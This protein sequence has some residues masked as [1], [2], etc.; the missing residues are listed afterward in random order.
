M[1][2]E[3]RRLLRPDGVLVIS[4]PERKEYSEL[5]DFK[6]EYH[7]HEFYQDEFRTFLED[8]FPCVEIFGQR[9]ISASATWP[10][11]GATP[12]SSLQTDPVP[13]WHSNREVGTGL[14]PPQYCI[15]VCGGPEAFVQ[16]RLS[17][18]FFLLLDPDQQWMHEHDEAVQTRGDLEHRVLELKTHGDLVLSIKDQLTT[19]N[20]RLNAELEHSEL[21]AQRVEQRTRDALREQEL[22]DH[23]PGAR[24][25]TIALV[26]Q[27]TR[28]SHD[29]GS[30]RT[31]NGG[32]GDPQRRARTGPR[33]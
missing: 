29:R 22:E 13:R 1:L 32:S 2:A 7:E 8:V 11:T 3:A 18:S 10:L 20:D 17:R 23:S 4:T 5:R 19:D 28:P 30:D 21:R 27:H 33:P 15:A 9:V 25:V 14:P 12:P 6:N 16:D 24:L 26:A 31:Q